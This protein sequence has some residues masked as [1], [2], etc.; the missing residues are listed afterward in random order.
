MTEGSL[1]EIFAGRRGRLLAAL[2]A[3]E[4]GA[5]VTGIAYSTVLPVASEELHGAG[6]YGAC[7]VAA[8]LASILVLATGLGPLARLSARRTLLL[9]TVGFL[10][11]VALCAGAWSMWLVLAGMV[12][13]GLAGGLLAGFGL[14]AIGALY[15]DRLRP[16]VVGLFAVVWLVPSL[17]GPVLNSVVTLASSWRVAM[18]WPAV[19]VVLA[20]VLVGRDA[21][22]VPWTREQARRLDVGPALLLLGGLAAAACAPA[23]GGAAGIALLVGGVA[24]AAATS[25][26][27]LRHQVGDPGRLRV[28]VT[29]ALLCLAFFGGHQLASLAAVAGLGRGVVTAAVT[30][31][32]AQV[33]WS[34][35]GLRRGGRRTPLGDAPVVGLALVAVGLAVL[36]ATLLARPDGPVGPVLLVGGWTVGGTGMGVAYR[37]L[38]S[39]ALGGLETAAVAPAAVALEFA[40][41]A[42]TTVGS[43]A[44]GGWYS[45]GHVDGAPAHTTL[46][47]ALAVLAVVAVAAALASAVARTAPHTVPVGDERA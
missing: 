29:F 46:G 11:G 35:T 40:E 30:V 36:A 27:V 15:D 39:D 19:L 37:Q 7:V 17:A 2:L 47:S 45:L 13:R 22:L 33:A 42:A 21:D 18:A 38:F 8:N 3:A 9:A 28:M 14:T 4:L 24:L 32:A 34:L 23:A 6:L 26:T 12:V 31:G 5:A 16:R 41:L 10:L 44:V 1:R 43:L 20:R 25:A